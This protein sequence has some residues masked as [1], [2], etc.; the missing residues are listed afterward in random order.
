MNVSDIARERGISEILHFTTNNGL[1]GVLAKGF[2]LSRRRLPEDDYLQYI[3]KC[4]SAIRPENS[5]YFDKSKDW[6]DYVNLSI[7]EVN[8]RFFRVSNGWHEASDVWWAIMSFDVEILDHDGVYFATTNNGYDLCRRNLGC[9]GFDLLFAQKIA[10]KLGWDAF[11]AAREEWLPTCEQAEVL[12]PSGL[13]T[14][15]LRKVYVGTE[16]QAD[17]AS[18]FL[19]TFSFDGVEVVVSVDKFLGKLN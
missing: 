11:R 10:R 13:S 9:A 17:L 14:D 18:S 19:R 15:F 7:S 4:N 16:E 3:M 12:Y 2:L 8:R 6:L 5:A 1:V